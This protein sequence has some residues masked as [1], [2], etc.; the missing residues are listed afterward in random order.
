MCTR[1]FYLRICIFV[2][3]EW[4]G[5][6]LI[7][8]FRLHIRMVDSTEKHA[9][10]IQNA[11]TRDRPFA[12]FDSFCNSTFETLQCEFCDAKSLNVNMNECFVIHMPVKQA[13][14]A[15]KPTEPTKPSNTIYYQT[16]PRFSI[17]RSLS[18]SL[19]FSHKHIHTTHS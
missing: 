4:F 14:W 19:S 15:N 17:S 6:L 12:R 18:L 11:N 9:G 16:L 13:K 10:C 7:L 1:C 2:D 5:P 8:P 3:I